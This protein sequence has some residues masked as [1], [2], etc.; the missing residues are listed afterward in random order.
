[1]TM[2]HELR[3]PVEARRYVA[4]GLWLQRVLTPRAATLPETLEWALELAGCGEPL[5]P[6]GFVADVGHIVFQPEI[7]LG[8]ETAH[9][10]G[11]PEG[12]ARTYEDYV[13][14][15]FLADRGIERA[16]DALRQ[17][18]GRDRGRG[19]ACLLAQLRQRAGLD[20]VHL[21][22][23]VIKALRERPPDDVL[24]EGWQAIADQGPLPILT[25][26]YEALISRIRQT[27]DLL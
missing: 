26:H 22:P 15:K 18:H 1:M 11:W 12:L 6:V 2:L 9:V 19:L 25:N 23:A 10:P 14:G 27:A 24:A 7:L 20:G 13:L 5:P 17:Y 21:N 3:D 4:Q 16:S 8:R